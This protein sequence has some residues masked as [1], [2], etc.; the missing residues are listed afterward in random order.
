MV[1]KKKETKKQML[2]RLKRQRK[3]AGIG[4]FSKKRKS[5]TR[6]R[7]RAVSKTVRRIKR[8]SSTMA[9]KG[10]RRS[11]KAGLL[12]QKKVRG[13]V[14]ALGYA[15]VGEPIL[16]MA[17]SKIGLNTADEFIK[18]LGGALISMNSTG[19]IKSIGDA[20]LTISAYKLGQQYLPNVLSGI[21]LGTQNNNNVAVQGH[22]TV[23]VG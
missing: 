6:S 3:K 2:A 12:S 13:I 22:S 10:K 9:K 19:I 11:K 4:E 17:A 14:G 15:V 8:R 1:K 5:V 20:A 7:S 18:G 21:G 23:I 16:D